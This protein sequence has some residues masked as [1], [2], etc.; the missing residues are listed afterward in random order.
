[1]ILLDKTLYCPPISDITH[2]LVHFRIHGFSER[3]DGTGSENINNK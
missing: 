1:M 3:P 2:D